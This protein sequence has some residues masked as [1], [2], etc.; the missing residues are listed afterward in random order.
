M[1]KGRGTPPGDGAA[2]FVNWVDR[3]TDDWEAV[4]QHGSTHDS[5]RDARAAVLAWARAKPAALPG[6][7]RH[8][9]RPA[10]RR[11]TRGRPAHRRDRRPATPLAYRDRQ[12]QDHPLGDHRP[13][14]P[15]T[16]S[17]QPSPGRART[18]LGLKAP[19]EA[20]AVG[21]A[22]AAARGVGLA[23]AATSVMCLCPIRSGA[24]GGRRG[25]ARADRGGPAS[26]GSRRESG[27]SPDGG[28][29]AGL[30]PDQP[31]AVRSDQRFTTWLR[32]WPRPR[33]RLWDDPLPLPWPLGA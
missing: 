8:R 22:R 29:V 11:L 5:L 31:G 20:G 27:H 13:P 23:C 28:A 12:H 32:L 14:V 19:G 24:A 21:R 10:H 18:A 17:R 16:V 4:W 1:T 7:Q 6:L 25:R 9:V 33:C 26:W 3:D 15:G 2:V 30:G